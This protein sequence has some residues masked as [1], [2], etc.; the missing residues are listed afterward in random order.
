MPGFIALPTILI[1]ALVLTG[2]AFLRL[3]RRRIPWAWRKPG[4]L[5]PVSEQ[6]LADRRRSG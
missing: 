5:S 3:R 1:G 4:E 6:W 2:Y